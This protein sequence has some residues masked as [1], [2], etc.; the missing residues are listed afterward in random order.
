MI[1]KI[2]LDWINYEEDKNNKI[3]KLDPIIFANSF[4]FK[5]KKLKEIYSENI[6]IKS[7][8]L[9]RKHNV[10]IISEAKGIKNIK[11][12]FSFD[13]VLKLFYIKSIDENE[14][15]EIKNN[16]NENVSINETNIIKGLKNKDEFIIEKAKGKNLLLQIS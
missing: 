3:Q 6:S 12:N 9:D 8:N 11:L 4:N 16:L 14:I 15:T 13:Q 10:H 7:K 2:F 5:G 1:Q